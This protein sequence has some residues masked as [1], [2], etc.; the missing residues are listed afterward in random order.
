ML[1]ALL[2]VVF[3]TAGC[4]R[5]ESAPI[6]RLALETEPTTLD[7]AHA[8]DYS[9]GMVTSLIHSTLVR[10]S[11]DGDLAADLAET[12]EISEGADVYVF[13]LAKARFSNGRGVEADDVV[14]SFKRLLDPET[15]SPRWWVL[16]AVLG[17]ESY[18]VGGTWNDRS[19]EAIDDSTVAVRL[20]SP[21]SHFLSL[22]T[23]PAAAIVCREEVSR[24]GADYG[25][26]PCGSGPWVLAGW[27]EGDGLDLER[28]PYYTGDTASIE[29]ISLRFIPE[30]MTRVAEFE[31]GNLDILEV[32]R[33]ELAL[34]RSAGVALL[35]GEELR[36]VYIGLNNTRP[37]FDD[38]R[39][40][41][42]VNMAVDVESIIANVLFG[43]AHRARGVVPPG[44]RSSPEPEDL[45]RY[46]PEKARELLSE[47]GYSS[48]MTIE[49]W[50]RE[51]PE[52]GRILESVQGFLAQVGIEVNLVTREWGAFKQAV[53][54]GTPDA[55]YLDWFADYPDPEN[56]L[57]PLFHSANRGGKGNR[58]GYSN[59]AVDT[60]L[61]AAAVC[62]DSSRRLQLLSAAEEIIYGDAPWIFLWFPIRYEVVSPRLGGYR[63][64]AV[65]NSQLYQDVTLRRL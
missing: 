25:R 54:Q 44:L 15:V 62:R 27:S 8:V 42:A 58:A 61:E 41:R 40:R 63:M 56:F 64:P 38:V 10:Y 29:G 57:V 7:P 31:V 26:S 17:A 5:E 16:G 28:N 3:M 6:L 1:V 39:V 34:W 59:G 9:S 36:I 30:A 11:P 32:P 21:A 2:L 19:V 22:L 60:L 50:Q 37:P 51:N 20:G 43:A 47:A 48:G 12:W 35:S 33:V 53:D 4:S 55:F 46:D 18:H 13:H 49:I 14:F 24:L 45:Y 52:G 65:F 23:M